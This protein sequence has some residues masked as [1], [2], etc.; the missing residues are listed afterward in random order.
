M[1]HE[2]DF[3]YIDRITSNIKSDSDRAANGLASCIED[4]GEAINSLAGIV[5]DLTE[6][7]AELKGKVANLEAGQPTT[8]ASPR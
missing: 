8:E 1:S 4:L 6:E 3:A 5:T 2:L 7:V